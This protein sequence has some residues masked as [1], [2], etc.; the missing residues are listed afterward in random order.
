TSQSSATASSGEYSTLLTLVPP[1][2]LAQGGVRGMQGCRD[3]AHLY[4]ERGGDIPILD[5]CEVA[6]E[7][8]EALALG[9]CCEPDAQLGVA[10]VVTAV[11]AVVAPGLHDRTAARLARPVDDATPHPPLEW[12]AT[13][14]LAGVAQGIGE[15][16]LDRL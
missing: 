12:P 7:H 16:F 3:R 11:A 2:T 10:R 14:P 1:R 6:Q 13:L 9:Q 5:V 8:D 4:P 15:A